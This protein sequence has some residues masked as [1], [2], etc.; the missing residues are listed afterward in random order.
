MLP[1]ALAER[2][3]RRPA[4]L[5][6]RIALLV[7][8]GTLVTSLVVTSISIHSIHGFLGE[9]INERFPATLLRT[10]EQLALW[11]AQRE[12]DVDALSR[13]APL[14]EGLAA[15][16]AAPA[17]PDA[18]LA[19]EQVREALAY[20]LDRYDQYEGLF[21]LGPE[22]ELQAH[23]GARVRLSEALR[24]SLA[25]PG[26][27]GVGDLL[28]GGG[29]GLQIASAPVLGADGRLLGS[30]HAQIR[31]EALEGLLRRAEGPGSGRI[32][33]VGRDGRSLIDTSDRLAGEP[34]GRPL[35]V[36]GAVA[37]LEDYRNAA[38][39]RV[40][41]AALLFEEF[42]WGIA[43]EEPYGEAFAPVVRVI[44]RVL[45]INLTIVLVLGLVALQIANSIAR[46][47]RALSDGVR[48]VG[49][50]ETDVVIMD[51]STPDEIGLLTRTFNRMTARLHRN[52]LELQQNRREIEAA[53]AR[54][55][56][57]NDELQRVNRALEELSTT[58]GLTG[59]YN[60]RHFQEELGRE[61]KRAQRTGEPL[62]LILL[63]IDDFK[64]LNDAHGHAA[65][66]VVLRQVADVMRQEIRDTDLLAR[67]GGEEFALL[68][69]ETDLQGA[70]GLAE[71]LRVAVAGTRF[72]VDGEEGPR[73]IGITV[74]IG[75]SVLRD[76]RK[77]LFNDAD[78][79]M[80][81]AKASGKDCVVVAS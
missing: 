70:S 30:L 52:R 2:L 55:R 21:V 49:E 50:G 78:R 80:Y 11:Y 4:G 20:A 72:R 46:P 9:E 33:L 35:P 76:N 5:S 34:Y 22:G 60:H 8:G 56:E 75:V 58:D 15:L 39:E 37:R 48:R 26:A 66:D 18:A 59:V 38:G 62:A 27:P 73:T 67:Y 29:R 3:W 24:A 81:R 77:G 44:G 7:F 53:N 51:V 63:D 23:V 19:R 57:Q 69:P 41:G 10:R 71:K 1:D 47:I 68:A 31:L 64:R 12:V 40:V 42:G 79:A 17:P 74:S 6:T 61:I 45:A 54:L 16:H 25:S 43:V 13:G 28:R 14:L 65:G 36:A 32:F